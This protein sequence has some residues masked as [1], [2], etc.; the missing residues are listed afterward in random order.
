MTAPTFPAGS[1]VRARGRD[2]LVIP[3]GTDG[4]LRARPLGGTDA[5]TTLLLPEQDRPTP[6]IFLPPKVDD[7]G[8]AS[9]ARLLRDALRLS[10]QATGGPF[11]SFAKIAVT[12]RNYQLVPLMMAAAQ[13]TSPN[14]RRPN[15]PAA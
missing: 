4:M 7:R 15:S 10:F 12:P 14:A 11:R 6:A 5:E 2:W 9:R 13:N 8:D 1:L 3:G